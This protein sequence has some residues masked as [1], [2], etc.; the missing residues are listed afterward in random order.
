MKKYG[1]FLLRGIIIFLALGAFIFLLIE[2]TTEGRNVHATLFQIYFQDPFLLYAYASSIPFF[3]GMFHIWKLVGN[4]GKSKADPTDSLRRLKLI[5]RCAL[6]VTILAVGAVMYFFLM[7]RNTE[8]IAGGVAMG[9]MI[10]IASIVVAMG[11]AVHG[12]SFTQH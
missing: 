10:I 7:Q 1:P 4:A 11:A 5:Q 9:M 6:T 12:K 3:V 8:D 2:P